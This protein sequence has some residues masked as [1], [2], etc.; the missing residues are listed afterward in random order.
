MDGKATARVAFEIL[1]WLMGFEPTTTGITIQ[2]STT[3]LQPPLRTTSGAPDRIRTCYP[4]LRRPVLYPIEL[5]APNRCRRKRSPKRIETLVGVIGFEPT[6]SCSQSKRAT[7][8]RYT[9]KT[10]TKLRILR[11]AAPRVN[12]AVSSAWCVVNRKFAPGHSGTKDSFSSSFGRCAFFSP[13][14][15][16]AADMKK[17]SRS[18]HFSCIQQ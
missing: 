4:R 5:R 15:L 2:D 12:L 16:N 14:F 18:C 3:E 13:V 17:G 6:T 11:V 9:P 7:G 1:G 10:A 8:L